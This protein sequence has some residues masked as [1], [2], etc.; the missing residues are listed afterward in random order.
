MEP[1]IRPQASAQIRPIT[2]SLESSHI[3][4]LDHA[5]GCWSTFGE[6]LYYIF[7]WPFVKL[8]EAFASLFEKGPPA[9]DHFFNKLIDDS[10]ETGLQL[11]VDA[12]QDPYG[13]T[14]RVFAQ[15]IHYPED[16]GKEL[17]K[18][19]FSTEPMTVSFKDPTNETGPDIYG[20]GSAHFEVSLTDVE[21]KAAKTA[22][23]TPMKEATFVK[24][25][26]KLLPKVTEALF[27]SL[28]KAMSDLRELAVDN[29]PG[30][31]PINRVLRDSG[32]FHV[33]FHA[34]STIPLLATYPKLPEALRHIAPLLEKKNISSVES[35]L[36]E[37]CQELGDY[38][39]MHQKGFDLDRWVDDQF[40][41][42]CLPNKQRIVIEEPQRQNPLQFENISPDP[43]RSF[44]LLREEQSLNGSVRIS[45]NTNRAPV[46]DENY[47]PA[48]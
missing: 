5:E 2:D 37:L 6:V 25:L 26:L 39:N 48:K 47:L 14:L 43:T 10:Y 28:V 24:E 8:Y 18:F 17:R 33:I 1:A 40:V 30:Q 19:F 42:R 32:L 41:T 11:G 21:K 7:A 36:Q 16:T 46:H 23:I 38:L 4:T 12:K 13:T 44:Q 3:A 45:S 29:H 20:K 27:P 35:L 22:S 31:E 15:F 34:R 9:N